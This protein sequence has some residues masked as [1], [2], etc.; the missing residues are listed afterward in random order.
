MLCGQC[1]KESCDLITALALHTNSRYS[2][3]SSSS[4]GDSYH[5]NAT[6]LLALHHDEDIISC[7][8]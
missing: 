7:L 8:I 6:Q 3:S 5:K 1:S 2:N 4:I